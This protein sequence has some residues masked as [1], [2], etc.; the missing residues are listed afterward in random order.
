[1]QTFL[2]KLKEA[3]FSVLPVVVLIF[4]CQLFG[5]INL[6]GNE[7]VLL[8]S[9]SV[10]IILG[11]CF[12][13]VGAEI[14]I[15]TMGE[16]VGSGLT[17]KNRLALLVIICFLLGV[18]ITIAEPDLQVLAK[19]CANVIGSTE[20]I[21]MIGLGVGIFLAIGI[22][23]MILKKDLG[24]ILMFFYFFAFALA[25]IVLENGNGAL[26]PL[27]FDSGGVTTGPI[28]VPFLMALG[29]G[30][31]HGFGGKDSQ[32]NS[33]GMV[34]LGS[35]GPILMMLVLCVFAKGDVAYTNEIAV[36]FNNIGQYVFS[37]LGHVCINVLRSLAMLVVFFLI[38]NFIFLK[39]PMIKLIK[40][41]I[42]IIYTYLGL[43][44]FLTSAEVG[45]MPLGYTIGEQLAANPFIL[46]VAGFLIGFLVIL[47]EPAVKILVHQ[48]EDITD[49]FVSKRS[50][51]ISLCIGVGIAIALSLI[52]VI[53]DF[54]LL[55]I[56]VPGYFISLGLSF[57]VPKIYTAIAFDSGGVASGPLTSSFI[58]SML[59]GAC[60][61]LQGNDNIMSL[62][63]GVISL[64]AMTPLITIQL[65]GFKSFVSHAVRKKTQMRRIVN[66]E[67]DCKIINFR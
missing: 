45:F 27:A 42:G 3:V 43:V 17:K 12:F 7:I 13:T 55:Y 39:L 9:T 25:S 64:V 44:L 4:I 31:A 46:V 66:S 21:L 34:A 18:L 53:F 67:E 22:I 2:E 11:I 61:T 62:A 57:F 50:M 14:S 37:S 8:L 51:F 52:R 36:D 56:I 32:A 49:G 54:S 40:M 23:K 48:V 28:T 1:M 58:L 41:G 63:F 33:F 6:N 10:T 15:A 47:A 65:L 5:F 59:I 35:I 24:Q 60:I 16:Q 26:L 20:L 19:Q 38:F 29:V 30:V